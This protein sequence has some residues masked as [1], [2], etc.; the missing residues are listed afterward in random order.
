MGNIFAV[1]DIHGALDNL[2]ALLDQIDEEI[3][4][5]DTLVFL[6]DY[7]DRGS[8]VYDVV[9]YLLG[10]KE[11]YG[12]VVFLKGNHEE[13]LGQYLVGLDK[14]TYLVNGGEH[15]LE[16]YLSRNHGGQQSIIPPEHLNFFSS[17]ALYYETEEFIF[18]HAGLREK[19]PLH[20]QKSADLL[21]IRDKFI[22]STYDFGKRVVFGHTPFKEPLIMPNKIGIDTGSVYGNK[23]TCVKLP[24]LQFFHAGPGKADFLF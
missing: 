12:H 16:S 3:T 19:V 17:L 2:I 8:Q 15:T 7:I 5:E 6:G 18:V 21:W 4:P 13:M 22:H 20:E 10:L 14:Y 9:E 11:R 23:L 24:Q 1:G